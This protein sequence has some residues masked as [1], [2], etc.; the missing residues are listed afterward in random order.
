M[1]AIGTLVWLAPL[2]LACRQ[3]QFTSWKLVV[4]MVLHGPYANTLALFRWPS[5]MMDRWTKSENFGRSRWLTGCGASG[6]IVR[7]GVD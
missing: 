3:S 1:A 6:I 5:V 2:P 7:D 4:V